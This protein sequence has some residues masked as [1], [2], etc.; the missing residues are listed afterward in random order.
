[1]T[2]AQMLLTLKKE[3]ARDGQWTISAYCDAM[4]RLGAIRFNFGHFSCQAFFDQ[5]RPD[6]DA[7]QIEAVYNAFLTRKL[8]R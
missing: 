4:E 5:A 6:E 2:P 3:H 1:M 8:T 7:E